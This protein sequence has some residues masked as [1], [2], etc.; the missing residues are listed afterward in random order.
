MFKIFI[1]TSVI[2]L[3]IVATPGKRIRNHRPDEGDKL[4]RKSDDA[5]LDE[6]AMKKELFQDIFLERQSGDKLQFG[7]VC[8]NPIQ[9][10]QRFEEKDFLEN[11]HRGKVL[12]SL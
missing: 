12:P 6:L 5:I 8:E 1:V 10:E 4:Q 7:Y 11:R 3:F 9:W 2:F